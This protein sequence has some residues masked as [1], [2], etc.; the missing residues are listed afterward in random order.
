MR[1]YLKSYTLK[2]ETKAPVFIGDGSMIGNREYIYLQRQQKVIIPNLSRLDDM[3]HD[4]GLALEFRHFMLGEK[5]PLGQWLRDKGFTITDFEKV[6]RYELDAGDYFMPSARDPGRSKPP[7]DI[8]SF[9]K[10]PYG[11]PYVPG[12]SLKGVMRSALLAAIVNNDK[13]VFSKELS[14]IAECSEERGRGRSFLQRE[15]ASLESKAFHTLGCNEKRPSDAVNSIM[16]GIV[17]SD[18]KPLSI[19]QLTLCQKVDLTLDGHEK[20]LPILRECLKPSTEIE[21]QMTIDESVFPYGVDTILH[22]LDEYNAV[23]YEHFGKKFHRGNPEPGILWLG[24]GTGYA[25]KTIS[26]ALFNKRDAMRIADRAFYH[27]LGRKTYDLHHHSN[28]FANGAAPHIYKC[29]H[30]QGTTY[31]MGMCKIVSINPV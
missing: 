8:N 4:N 23:Y 7:K 16:S 30:Y 9:I 14:S 19:H 15:T 26:Y 29:T 20:A 22:A 2:V 18:S 24:G 1:D 25:T 5:Q 21:F 3:L 28:D 31:D 6:K 13:D 17:V 11:Y 27:G 10:D 12:S